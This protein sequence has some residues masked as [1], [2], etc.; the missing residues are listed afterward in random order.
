[1]EQL[2]SKCRTRNVP[3]TSS[4]PLGSE[5]IPSA[6]SRVVTIFHKPSVPQSAE[7]S[8]GQLTEESKASDI[9]NRLRHLSA[10]VWE[11]KRSFGPDSKNAKLNWSTTEASKSNEPDERKISTETPISLVEPRAVQTVRRLAN[12]LKVHA[13]LRFKCKLHPSH[14]GWSWVVRHAAW[15]HNRFHVKANGRTCFEELHQSRYKQD[16]V[17][18]AEKVLF[19]E[20]RP[21]HRRLKGGRRAQKMDAAMEPGI[22]LGR[23]EESDEHLVGTARGVLRARTVRRMTPDQMWDPELFFGFRGVPW[24]LTADALPVNSDKGQGSKRPADTPAEAL[25]PRT[26]DY[27]EGISPERPGGVLQV[28]ETVDETPTPVPEEAWHLLE[29]D[30][31]AGDPTDHPDTWDEERWG[32]EMHSGKAREL[33]SLADYKVYVPVPREESQGKKEFRWKDSSRDDLFGVTSW[34]NT[35]RILDYVMTKKSLRAYLA[36]CHCTFFHAPEEEEVYVE[37]PD[38]WKQRSADKE[39]RDETMCGRD[40][41]GQLLKRVAEYMTLTLEGPFDVGSTFV[42]LKRVRTVTPEGL[43]ISASSN[44][45]K[46]LMKLT[47]LTE[48]SKGKDTPITKPVVEDGDEPPA[49]LSPEETTRFRAV[50]GILMYMSTD[51]PDIQYVV[52]ELSGVMSKP[53]QRSWEAAIAPC[54]VLDSH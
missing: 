17:P 3:G 21:K 24:D 12:S 43:Y 42:H 38:E 37:P 18:W 28:Y 45:L 41:A 13:E 39:D 26:E 47:D 6:D 51:C 14:P 7:A 46:K 25:D 29:S 33:Q 54:A 8:P 35:G 23:T 44:H 10:P 52:N 53:T 48:N 36:D 20:R 9:R 11:P 27:Q 2:C 34:A 15:L 22:W 50:V 49:E 1:M 5:R 16:V 32:Q 19:M 4:E 40:S 30:D 31:L